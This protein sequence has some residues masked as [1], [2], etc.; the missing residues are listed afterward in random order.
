MLLPPAAKSHED[1]NEEGDDS[2]GHTLVELRGVMKGDPGAAVMPGTL[3]VGDVLIVRGHLFKVCTV[4]GGGMPC[5]IYGGSDLIVFDRKFDFNAR[6]L[7]V[8]CCLPVIIRAKHGLCH[9]RP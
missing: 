1:D 9:D 5:E 3:S 8:R 4:T 7:A 6:K 2:D